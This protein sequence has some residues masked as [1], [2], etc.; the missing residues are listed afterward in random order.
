MAKFG[1]KIRDLNDSIFPGPNKN[2]D[3]I[4]GV[5]GGESVGF[6]R[7]L[8]DTVATSFYS[9][10]NAAEASGDTI[11]KGMSGKKIVGSIANKYALFNYQGMYGD[12]ATDQGFKGNYMDT[13][14]AAGKLMGGEAGNK[15]TVMKIIN[16]FNEAHP[17][18]GYT[19]SNFLYSKYYK[20]IP[21]N[22]LITLR[23]F[24]MPVKDNIFKFS[25]SQAVKQEVKEGEKPP[26]EDPI[27]VG[28]TSQVAGVT[29]ITYMGE[30]AGNKLED[31]MNMSFG[32]TFKELKGE[33]EKIEGGGDG[34]YTQ[35]P[36]YNKIG[37]IGRAIAN[38][39]KG[40]GSGDVF[41]KQQGYGS[42]S[43]DRLGST[44]ANFVLGP[45][46]V[47]NTTQVRDRGINFTND[48]KLNFEYELKSLAYV[49]PKI[50]MIDIISNMLTMTTNNGAF[51][52]GG[53]RYYGSA[54]FV[55]S[56]FGDISKLRQGDFSGYAGSVVNDI[57]GGFKSVFGTA[58]GG[59]DFE[60][61][62]SGGI[63][64]AK[65]YLGGLLGN[66]LGGQ[67]GGNSGTGATKAFISGEPTG[68]W[69]LTIGNPLNPIAMMG[70]MIC[71][72][73]NMTLGAGL[74]YDDFPMEVKFELDM[75]HGK[76]RDKGD[77]EN[78]FNAGK[79]RIYASANKA[80]DI[81][82]LSGKEIKVYGAIPN[83]GT[84]SIQKTQSGAT[85]GQVKSKDI[86]NLK[87]TTGSASPA[88]EATSGEYVS[89]VVS[90]LIDS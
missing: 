7:S 8:A 44:Y 56:Q 25:E 84:S 81:L 89:S 61:I 83:V 88:T 46:N 90:M 58:D 1:Q 59:F 10:D 77:I 76:P 42:Q 45:I 23:R 75:A 80:E 60:S 48:I 17:K 49:N 82:N 15:P 52:G 33:M 47:V 63:E 37:G 64:T 41:R 3:Q 27:V 35:Q 62:L 43:G 78:M 4:L 54:G 12:F 19:A 67:V 20:K 69:H 24:P 5:F 85:A 40:Q 36:F 22:H 29:A 68:D 53:H 70:N 72:N 38:Q 57:E 74:G 39:A 79:G 9:A 31:I 26:P 86:S 87:K 21:V 30:T 14:R 73:A 28:D 11:P 66:L 18:I 6:A 51:F 55:A 65:N 32:L 50:A 71:K 13:E 34:G 2:N 16:Y